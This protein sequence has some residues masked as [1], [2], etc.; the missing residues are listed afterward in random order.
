VRRESNHE[1]PKTGNPKRKKA[2][3]IDPLSC[4]IECCLTLIQLPKSTASEF[5]TDDE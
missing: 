4:K 5:F 2:S 1:P 3:L